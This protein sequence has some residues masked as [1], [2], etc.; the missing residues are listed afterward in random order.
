MRIGQIYMGQC[1]VTAKIFNDTSYLELRPSNPERVSNTASLHGLYLCHICSHS[2]QWAFWKI[3]VNLTCSSDRCQ[4]GLWP[5][6]LLMICVASPFDACVVFLPN[7]R[8]SQV[9]MEPQKRHDQNFE[10]PDERLE[11]SVWHWPVTLWT[12]R[13]YKHIFVIIYW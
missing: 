6:E 13:C 2:V 5:T 11:R 1:M 7:M 10:R 12:R 8:Q 3:P 4:F 9:D